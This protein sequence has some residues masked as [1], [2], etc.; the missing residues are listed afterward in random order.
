LGSLTDGG[1]SNN[2]YKI[3]IYNRKFIAVPKPQTPKYLTMVNNETLRVI[4]SISD[5][6]Q[7]GLSPKAVEALTTLLENGVSPEKLATVIVEVRRQRK[8]GNQ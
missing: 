8:D 2:K 3:T 1:V 7:S 5:K 6:V 4:D